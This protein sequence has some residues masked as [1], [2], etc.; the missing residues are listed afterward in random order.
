M[1]KLSGLF[2]AGARLPGDQDVA[3]GGGGPGIYFLI[4]RIRA[5][6]PMKAGSASPA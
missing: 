5:V 2:L 6:A 4:L 3:D 1:D